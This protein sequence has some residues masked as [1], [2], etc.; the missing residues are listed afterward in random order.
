MKIYWLLPKINFKK[1]HCVQHY[2]QPIFL[3][4]SVCFVIA[5]V[6]PKLSLSTRFVKEKTRPGKSSMFCGGKKWVFWTVIFLT[7]ELQ[8]KWRKILVAVS[9]YLKAS[10]FILRRQLFSFVF[11]NALSHCSEDE[12]CMKAERKFWKTAS[13]TL[14]CKSSNGKWQRPL[15]KNN[16]LKSSYLI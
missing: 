12:E 10:R 11:R 8:T 14:G 5:K 13:Y 6:F 2:L 1:R 16:T 9:F 7:Q 4:K 3:S 15:P